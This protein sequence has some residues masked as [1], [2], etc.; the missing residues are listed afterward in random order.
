MATFTSN[1]QHISGIP[2]GGL[3][4]G[5]V[6]IRP[7]GHFH[8]WQLFNL[9]AWAPAQ[10]E[11]CAGAHGPEMPSSACAFFI[12]TQAGSEE[13]LIRHLGTK[14]DFNNPYSASWM[15]NVEA[16]EFQGR[17]PAARL[18]Y[19]DP[20]LP[21]RVSAALCSP[22]IPHEHELSGTPGL[23]VAFTLKNTSRRTQNVSL[24]GL[25]KNPLA[26]GAD[27]RRLR[28]DLAQRDGLTCVT[29]RTDAESACRSTL[30]SMSLG[31]LDGTASHITGEHT[32]FFHGYIART[33]GMAD[34]HEVVFHAWRETGALPNATGNVAP[35]DAFGPLTSDAIAA[36]SDEQVRAALD[37]LRAYA[38]AHGL[39][40]RVARV[41]PTLLDTPEGR[42]LV[43][44]NLS[45]QLDT[46]TGGA[47][48]GQTWGDSA[49]SSARR[50]A[51]GASCE[52]VFLLAWHFPN[53]YSKDGTRLG[54][55]YEHR[56]ADAAAVA[57][58][59]AE[60]HA[61][62]R[63][64]TLAFAD[65]LYDTSEAEYVADAW[66][67][68]L[69]SLVKSTWWTK[70]G[71]FGVWEGLGCCGFHTT[72][73]SYYAT[74]NLLALFPALQQRQMEMGARFQ[75]EDGR[76]HHMFA[77]DFAHVDNQF[78]RVDMNQQFV[79]MA[80]RDYLWTGDRK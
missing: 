46:L 60:H 37:G 16:V 15:K 12:R 45:K 40:E 43:L 9:G 59:L 29:M 61:D 28:N 78:E 64:R 31:V 25:L 30:G 39:F 63:S 68:Q 74:F 70:D 14:P 58:F 22:F 3:G 20:A 27:N 76:I 52:I 21:L 4:T 24:L 71:S 42:R 51:P 79:L 23:Y 50:L 38:F 55:Q 17:C 53:H 72:D 67:A 49:L 13:P 48:T 75:R 56:F 11:C 57:R 32:K 2:L 65:A 47:H 10:P 1:L 69:S 26:A 8:E 62:L 7:D 18:A 66:S 36:L 54:H 41:N 44:R 77:P 34:A 80:C 33:D 19:R 5:S 6:E 35:T 73:V